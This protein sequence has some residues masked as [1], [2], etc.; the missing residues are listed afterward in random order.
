VAARCRVRPAL[1]GGKQRWTTEARTLTPGAREDSQPVSGDLVRKPPRVQRETM[2]PQPRLEPVPAPARRFSVHDTLCTRRR[3]A[4]R[5]IGASSTPDRRRW[6]R[7][8]PRQRDARASATASYAARTRQVQ[9]RS[10]LRRSRLALQLADHVR[11]GVHRHRR[12]VHALEVTRTR[13]AGA[14]SS[15]EGTPGGASI[16]LRRLGD[17]LDL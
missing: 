12:R 8:R 14:R 7:R 2:S 11:E 5:G 17:H 16:T 10:S 6:S 3:A 4:P 1:A 15:G 9:P 13:G